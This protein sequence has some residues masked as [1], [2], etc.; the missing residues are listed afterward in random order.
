MSPGLHSPV[1]E[2]QWV[3]AQCC[4]NEWIDEMLPQGG[5]LEG[6]KGGDWGP[7]R[8]EGSLPVMHRLLKPP[9]KWEGMASSR[10][11]SSKPDLNS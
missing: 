4:L 5:S 6:S 1:H 8:N 11:P 3:P 2:T 9:K 7:G 10:L